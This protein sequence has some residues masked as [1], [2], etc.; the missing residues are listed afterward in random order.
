MRN[1]WMARWAV[2]AACVGALA[3]CGGGGGSA[4][5]SSPALK[6][7]YAPATAEAV[8]LTGSYWNPREPGTGIFFEV[9]GSAG[10]ATF[11]VFDTDGRPTYYSAIGDLQQKGA[12]VAFAAQL[13]RYQGA[14]KLEGSE[15]VGNVEIAFDGAGHASV[16]LPARAFEV[17]KFT[18]SAGSLPSVPEA[19]RSAVQ[20]ESG[21]Y[22]TPSENGRGYTIE[23]VNGHAN[24]GV[25]HFDDAGDPTW[26]LV[27]VAL[28]ADAKSIGDFATFRGGQ[29][30]NGAYRASTRDAGTATFAIKALGPCKAL[31]QSPGRA[32]VEVQRFAFTPAE[33]CRTPGTPVFGNPSPKPPPPAQLPAGVT[34]ENYA[35]VSVNMLYPVS[36]PLRATGLAQRGA[37]F[38]IANG[39]L[40]N[41]VQVDPTTGRIHGV[42]REGG[43]F[44]ATIAVRLQ[45]PPLTTYV[46]AKLDVTPLTLTHNFDF[47]DAPVVWQA[48]YPMPQMQLYLSYEGIRGA[49]AVL[50]EGTSVRYGP[51]QTSATQDSQAL[52]GGGG[53]TLDGRISGWPS[54]TL[55][56]RP[57]QVVASVRASVFYNSNTPIY[58]RRDIW[59]MTR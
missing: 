7:A 24:V 6:A 59:F 43:Q 16:Q 55:G 51:V 13:R 31:L 39:A 11:F 47:G 45:D 3:A 50:P 40:P 41:G 56:P 22:W 9:Q 33:P 44:T 32:P 5:P 25:Y 20:L 2:M 18:L 35:A 28:G 27:W 29:T 36:M 52:P 1:G 42:T 21:I 14:P 58:I 19:Q 53:V 54:A 10:V 26:H 8:A 38:S 34:L 12:G 46:D 37:Q 4:P 48:G 57:S 30:L 23:M 49:P 15:A 17:E